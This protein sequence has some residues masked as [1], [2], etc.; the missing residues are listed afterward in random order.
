[1]PEGLRHPL[2]CDRCDTVVPGSSLTE[3]DQGGAAVTAVS[4]LEKI[5]RA[6]SI[7][8]QRKEVS[9]LH[10]FQHLYFQP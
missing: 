8:S 10:S 4:S 5:R 1:M 9:Y 3:G 2:R 6:D 7:S